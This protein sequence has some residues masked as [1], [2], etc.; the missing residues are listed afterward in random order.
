MTAVP[1]RAALTVPFP[2]EDVRQNLFFK[3]ATGFVPL[4]FVIAFTRP[5]PLEVNFTSLPVT[6]RHFP[7]GQGLAMVMLFVST[8]HN[9]GVS[10][11]GDVAKYHVRQ[12]PT[13]V[14]PKGDG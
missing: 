8:L 9:I 11:E 12:L 13:Q 10:F 14:P 4:V 7:F 6:S 2:V 3:A 5:Q 1:L